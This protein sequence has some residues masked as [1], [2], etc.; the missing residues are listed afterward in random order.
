MTHVGQKLCLGP[1]ARL[2]LVPGLLQL[3]HLLLEQA[4]VAQR[5]PVALVQLSTDHQQEDKINKVQGAEYGAV[6]RTDKHQCQEA[7][8]KHEHDKCPGQA[9][10]GIQRRRS[11]GSKARGAERHEVRGPRRKVIPD[12]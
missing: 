1:V 6:R 9:Q 5:V 3:H 7:G 8:H 11:P 12:Q 4:R 2:G 10:V